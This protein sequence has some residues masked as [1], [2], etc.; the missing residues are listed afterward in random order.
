M[1]YGNKD[2]VKLNV[3]EFVDYGERMPGTFLLIRRC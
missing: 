3:I 1:L 2:A